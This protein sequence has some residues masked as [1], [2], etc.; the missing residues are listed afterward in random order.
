MNNS[1]GITGVPVKGDRVPGAPGAEL[2]LPPEGMVTPPDFA[3][4]APVNP[5]QSQDVEPQAEAENAENMIEMPTPPGGL[6]EVEAKAEPEAGEPA[7]DED[8]LIAK[9]KAIPIEQNAERL[10]VAYAKVVEETMSNKNMDDPYLAAKRTNEIKW[11]DFLPKIF[12]RKLGDG[13]NGGG[14]EDGNTK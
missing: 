11:D 10:P 4:N 3:E 1:G 2:P 14:N 7:K 6:P 9:I 12:N 8:E 13:L 5:E